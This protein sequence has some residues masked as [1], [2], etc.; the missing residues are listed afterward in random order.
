MG[1]KEMRKKAGLTQR[2]AGAALGISCAAVAQWETDLTMPS[3]KRLLEVA[4]LY[5]CSVDELLREEEKS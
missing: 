2:E 5:G 3:G 4:A 1:F